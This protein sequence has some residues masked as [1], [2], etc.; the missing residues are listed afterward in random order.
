M[1]Q[2][3]KDRIIM[4]PNENMMARRDPITEIIIRAKEEIGN[5]NMSAL[6]R[7]FLYISNFFMLYDYTDEIR[8]NTYYS[9]SNQY[10]N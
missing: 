9:P 6:L 2:K 8:E 3:T 10:K 4:K 5:P 7:M 1:F